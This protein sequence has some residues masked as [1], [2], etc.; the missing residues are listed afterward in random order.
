[1]KKIDWNE[2]DKKFDQI[3]RKIMI[4][5]LIVLIIILT[6]IWIISIVY[7]KPETRINAIIYFIVFYICQIITGVIN[8]KSTVASNKRFNNQQDD[9]NYLNEEI[10]SLK[11]ELEIKKMENNLS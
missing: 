3:W 6:V 7:S 1:M 10:K 11:K 4:C 9:I 8:Y 2:V 5:Q